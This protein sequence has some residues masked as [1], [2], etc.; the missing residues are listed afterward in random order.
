[1]PTDNTM[2]GRILL[3]IDSIA[4]IAGAPLADYNHTHIFNPNWPPHA[5][6][7]NGQTINLAMTLGLFTL[8]YT[9]RSAATPT[10]HNEYRLVSA[11][12]GSIYWIA[13][14]ASLL[15]PGTMG[16]DP[17]F[18]GPGFPQAPLFV[19]CAIFAIVGS[20]MDAPAFKAKAKD[21]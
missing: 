6:F 14:I 11:F 2:L 4:L 5:K 19:G 1:M 17:E 13:G 7:H 8:F 15:Y 12:T 9:W 18:G 21:N 10:L 20:W 16:L 3:T